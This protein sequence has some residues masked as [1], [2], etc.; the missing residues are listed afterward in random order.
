MFHPRRTGTMQAG[1]WPKSPFTAFQR[2]C[3]LQPK[4]N[5][6][7]WRVGERK[8]DAPA[9]SQG[10]GVWGDQHLFSG[11]IDRSGFA[12]FSVRPWSNRGFGIAILALFP[13]SLVSIETYLP[14]WYAVV[15]LQMKGVFK[16]LHPIAS[17]KGQNITHI[18]NIFSVFSGVDKCAC[19]PHTYLAP[20]HGQSLSRCTPPSS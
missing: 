13:M 7:I 11:K 14:C 3:W 4:V 18:K 20:L 16:S 15:K 17:G 2:S 9:H 8:I 6:P 19:W 5:R 1:F 12:F 10:H